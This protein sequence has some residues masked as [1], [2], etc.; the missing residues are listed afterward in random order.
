[1]LYD[2]SHRTSFRY[3]QP[4]RFAR[5]NLRLEPVRWNGQELESH[6]LE[7]TP[8][9]TLTAMRPGGYP[10]NLVR[11]VLEQAA[12]EVVIE[13]RFRMRVDR[14]VPEI[15][16]DDASVAAVAAAARASGDL[17]PMGPANYL[18]ASPLIALEP[19]IV[20]WAAVELVPGRGVVEAGLALARRIHDEFL[21]DGCATVADTPPIEAFRGRHGVCQDFAQVMIAALRGHGLPAAYVSGYLRTI[22]PPGQPRLVGADATHAWVMLW[23]GPARG[24]IGFD[25]TNACLMASDHIVTALGR[26]YAD[27][28][29]IDGVFLGQD[30][31]MIE[32]EVDVAPVE[33]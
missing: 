26:D 17:S 12:S 30:Q 28:S 9:A 13:S 32:V 11:M 14:A 29:P 5:C 27:V 33:A 15:R 8:R 31:Q 6:A 25:P 16:S 18:S 10:V 2:V 3:A 23:C 24:W 4:V 1:M 7:V 21:Y 19:E 20:D 22:P